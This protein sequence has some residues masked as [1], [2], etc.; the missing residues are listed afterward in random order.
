MLAADLGLVLDAGELFQ[1]HL[2]LELGVNFRRFA[3]AFPPSDRFYV[4]YRTCPVFGGQYTPKNG[5]NVI[6]PT[7]GLGSVP[8]IGHLRNRLR[9]LVVVPAM[10]NRARNGATRFLPRQPPPV[11]AP[12]WGTMD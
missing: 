1:H 6:I 3:I 12:L 11:L 9:I 10:S 4:N 5:A 8:L 7:H 2:G